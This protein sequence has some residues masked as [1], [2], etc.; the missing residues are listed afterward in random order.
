MAISDEEAIKAASAKARDCYHRRL[1]FGT[2]GFYIFCQDCGGTWVAK[3]GWGADTEID[4]E[5]CNNLV[6]TFDE[7]VPPELKSR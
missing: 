3:R 4:Y 2:G 1:Q 6:S 7:R 5:R